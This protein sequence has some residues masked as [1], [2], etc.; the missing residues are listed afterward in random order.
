[1]PNINRIMSLQAASEGRKDFLC[2]YCWSFQRHSN[3]KSWRKHVLEDLR[4]YICTFQTC[5][6]KLFEDRHSWFQHETQNHRNKWRCNFCYQTPANP[7]FES[8]SSNDF[9]RHLSSRHGDKVPRAL[10]PA[11][12]Q[13]NRYLPHQI[14]PATCPFCDEWADALSKA[15]PLPPGKDLVV[16]PEDF[17]KH[18][19]SHLVE[20]A[21][22]ALPRSLDDESIPGSDAAVDLS[23]MRSSFE[24]TSL[25]LSQPQESADSAVM[26]LDESDSDSEMPHG[27]TPA[28]STLDVETVMPH[29]LSATSDTAGR[30]I[31][32][33]VPFARPFFFRITHVR[34]KEH[35]NQPPRLVPP[36]FFWQ[37]N[38]SGKFVAEAS[39]G[40]WIWDPGAAEPLNPLLRVRRPTT[41][42]AARYT[43]L[44]STTLI[45]DPERHNYI[46]A[47]IDC[48]TKVMEPLWRRLSFSGPK[49][50]IEVIG[51]SREGYCLHA[52]GPEHWFEQL[53]P[54]T[55]QAQTN[56]ETCSMLAGDLSILVG[57]I[58]FSARPDLDV[59]AIDQSFRSN[60]RSTCFQPNTLPK[61]PRFGLYISPC[62]YIKRL[63]RGL[64]RP[65]ER[66]H[67]H[68]PLVSAEISER[69]HGIKRPGDDRFAAGIWSALDLVQIW[70]GPVQAGKDDAMLENIFISIDKNRFETTL[71]NKSNGIEV[72]K[73]W[74]SSPVLGMGCLVG[75][76]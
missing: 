45:W 39:S 32:A 29:L 31:L 56:S 59:Q 55:C 47:P 11:I 8:Y 1:M 76:H 14:S 9:E 67:F 20:I 46:I 44:K 34:Y 4:P 15:N 13:S 63:A 68:E 75:A 54:D 73:I 42:E 6:L 36:D 58:A 50:R 30:P 18:V 3:E 27:A 26:A 72:R 51:F 2:H 40:L 74:G 69:A 66:E 7:E 10:L 53:L 24:N 19:G 21:L 57:L 16:T 38:S 64:T 65:V 5:G 17:M 12:I 60:L 62:L 37:P 71:H 41:A 43:T 35:P 22:F 23:T 48:T 28:D 49:R 52:M 61:S 70:D 25:N 33:G